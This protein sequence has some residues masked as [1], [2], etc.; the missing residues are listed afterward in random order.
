MKKRKLLGTVTI[1]AAIPALGFIL[2]F[3]SK[4][5]APL[6]HW[7]VVE[8]MMIGFCSIIGGIL[9]WR[10]HKWGYRLSTIGWAVILYASIMSL[11][12]AFQPEVNEQLKITMMSKDIIYLLVGIPILS[13]LIRDIIKTRT[14]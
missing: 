4:Y 13:I 5:N 3:I 14:V 8:K 10:G 6:Y 7:F 9:L 12:V 2:F 11:Y 1:I